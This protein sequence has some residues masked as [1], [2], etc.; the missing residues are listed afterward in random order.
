MTWT[1]NSADEAEKLLPPDPDEDGDDD[2]DEDAP[3]AVEGDV[4]EV[5][6][7][8]GEDVKSGELPADAL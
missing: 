5:D 4:T 1:A 2:P 7:A 6:E 8:D 3:D